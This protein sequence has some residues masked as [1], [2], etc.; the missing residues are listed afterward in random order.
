MPARLIRALGC[1]LTLT[2]SLLTTGLLAAPAPATA[3]VVDPIPLPDGPDGTRS[4]KSLVIGLDGAMLD[5]IREADA[6][7]MDA[8]M[9]D[10]TSSLA[11]RYGSASGFGLDPQA[12]T[13]SGPGW[14]TILTGVWPDKHGVRDNSFSGKDYATWPDYLTRAEQL[15]P[16][17]STFAIADWDPIATESAGG[18][19]ISDQ[20]DVRIGLKS[21]SDQYGYSVNDE[22]SA[23]AA[24]RYLAEQ[25]PDLAFVYFGKTDIA[26]HNSG[27]ASQ[28]FLDSLEAD[29][30]QI[31]QLLDAIESRPT[32]SQ[33]DWQ[34]VVSNDHGHTPGGGHGGNNLEERQQFV[35]AAGG[36]V[37]A[38]PERADLNVT[39][40][41]ASVYKHAGLSRDPGLDGTP[42]DEVVPDAFDT[43]RPQLAPRIDE[44]AI[45]AGL[46]GQT[47]TAPTGW[48]VDNSAMPTGGVADW[49]GW[50]F[51]TNEF[52]S[53]AER[54][55]G[56][57]GFVRG[58]N[59]IAV[60]DSDEWD[61]KA[62]G[63][64]AFDSTLVSPAYDVSGRRTAALDFQTWYQQENP[65]V[66]EVSVSFDGGAPQLVKS[67]TANAHGAQHFD[68]AVPAGARSLQVRFRYTGTNNWYWAVDQVV[69]TPGSA[70]PVTNPLAI[71]SNAK[72]QCVNGSATVAVHAR[73]VGTAPADIR[74]TT[75]WGDQ[76][77]VKV[78]P[79]SAVYRIF[80]A[81]KRRISAGSA[82]VAGYVWKDGQGF[83]DRQ[84]PAYAKLRC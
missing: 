72:S 23:D 51:A 73:N 83:Y 44:T 65:Q 62:H 67:Y 79:G 22:R 18:A 52:W 2:A 21:D 19:I 7:N 58:R 8:L 57:E 17:I 42:F 1:A 38:G 35:I 26:G 11:Y 76:K 59:V 13:L 75:K 20:V 66:G 32:Y 47:H 54:G 78:A 36:G 33:E 53:S 64:G 37:P 70:E 61:D 9:A 10:G 30:A 16:T 24:S 77:Y 41:V 63:A 39:D 25:D 48:S 34:I 81:G 82:T 5:K 12:S 43:L 45:P 60:A 14:S 29:D 27:S 69:V 68:V 55:Q 74:L 3:A 50:T 6:P 56:R 15:D 31:G 46:L 40:I 28:A 84:S 80:D 71:V 49:R 4:Q